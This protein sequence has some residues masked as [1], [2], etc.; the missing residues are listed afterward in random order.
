VSPPEVCVLD[1]NETLSDLTALVP[2]LVEVGLAGSD[3]EPWFAGVLRD[4]F[5]LTL[6]GRGPVFADIAAAGLRARLAAGGTDPG[7]GPGTD[8]GTN[9]GTRPGTDPGTDVDG[10]VAHVLA[11]F[12]AL[13][14]HADVAPGLRDLHRQGIALVP[15]TNGATAMS[16][17]MFADADLLGLFAHRLSVQEIGPWK[18]HPAPYAHALRTSGTSAERALMVAVHPWDLAGAAA[19]GLRTAWVDRGGHGVW[20]GHFDPPD[21]HVTGIDDLAR[22][23]ESS[24]AP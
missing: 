23:L 14:L 2:R 18:P 8:M 6:L 20:P 10:A 1:V 16:D 9:P 21:L 4:G 22:R 12:S 19:A 24:P 15:L 5:A 7:T 13:P 17:R 3:L 11:G